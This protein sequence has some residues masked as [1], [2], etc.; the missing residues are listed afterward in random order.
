[1]CSRETFLK[2]GEG[3]LGMTAFQGCVAACVI[4]EGKDKYPTPAVNFGMKHFFFG[5][6]KG[7]DL[8]MNLV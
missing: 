8:Q 7:S 5:G 3:K 6:R 1:M 4:S 2:H